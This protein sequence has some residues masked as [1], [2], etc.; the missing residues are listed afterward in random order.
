MPDRVVPI[1]VYLVVCLALLVFTGITIG[2]AHLNLGGLNSPLALAIAGLKAI[3]IAL[4]FMHLR[5]SPPVTRL[6]GLAALFWLG[7]LLVGTMDDILTRG[8][9]PIP[10][11]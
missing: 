8:W 3:L 2:F 11:K 6:V 7:L 5:W 1:R 9:L 4:Y 10:G